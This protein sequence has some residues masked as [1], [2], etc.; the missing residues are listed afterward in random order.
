MFDKSNKLSDS[1][2]KEIE[3]FFLGI[4]HH[5]LDSSNTYLG[6]VLK[7]RSSDRVHWSSFLARLSGNEFI[8]G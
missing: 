5:D 2:V 3:S 6:Q 8:K 4:R 1:K 7:T